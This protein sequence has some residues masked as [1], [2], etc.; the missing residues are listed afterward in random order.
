MPVLDGGLCFMVLRGLG[1]LRRVRGGT[2]YNNVWVAA[3]VAPGT[4]TH[5][6]VEGV[7]YPMYPRTDSRPHQR[8]PHCTSDK[9]VKRVRLDILSTLMLSGGWQL[10]SVAM[11]VD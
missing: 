5:T 11:T 2:P 1:V 9:G 3:V 8:L 6:G 10:P 4:L 7:G